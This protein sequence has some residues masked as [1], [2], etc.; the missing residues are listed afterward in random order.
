MHKICH[1]TN[2][3]IDKMQQELNPPTTANSTTVNDLIIQV[4]TFHA[5]FELI[6]GHVKQL[7]CN[8]A[9]KKKSIRNVNIV[10]TYYLANLADQFFRFF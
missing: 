9:N 6:K 10:A 7:L 5:S 2:S 3:N 4:I 8:S 1:F